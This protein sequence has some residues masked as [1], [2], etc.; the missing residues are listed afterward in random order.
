MPHR[1][2]GTAADSQPCLW[3]SLFPGSRDNVVTLFLPLRR[4]IHTRHGGFSSVGSG[5]C[6]TAVLITIQRQNESQITRVI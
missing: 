1:A 3:K 4:C 2:A 6:H 5:A